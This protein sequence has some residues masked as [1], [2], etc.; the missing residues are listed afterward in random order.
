MPFSYTPLWRKSIIALPEHGLN[1]LLYTSP[2]V[3]QND[4]IRVLNA[5]ARV[6]PHMKRLL[7]DAALMSRD[8]ARVSRFLSHVRSRMNRVSHDAARL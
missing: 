3:D 4:F 5:F 8:A 1:N 7:H 2:K 6:R